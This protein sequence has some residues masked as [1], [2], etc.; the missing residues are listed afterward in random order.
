MITP[1]LSIDQNTGKYVID[2]SGEDIPAINYLTELGNGNL[3]DIGI[4]LD[5]TAIQQA[6]EKGNQVYLKFKWEPA[7]P[8]YNID[9]FEI[10]GKFQTLNDNSYLY[11]SC[12]LPTIVGYSNYTFRLTLY[13]NMEE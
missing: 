7:D 1:I 4:I 8:T 10:P 5:Y 3:G 6:V 11:F 12:T 13:E 2:L 9:I